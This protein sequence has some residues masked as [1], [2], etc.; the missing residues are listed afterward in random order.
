MPKRGPVP[1]RPGANRPGPDEARL[2]KN[3]EVLK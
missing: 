3:W 2:N 1:R